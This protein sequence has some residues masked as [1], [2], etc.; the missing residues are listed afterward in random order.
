MEWVALVV[1]VLGVVGAMFAAVLDRQRELAL[2]RALGA[3][4][5]QLAA[6]L[7][8]EAAFLAL[9]AG[10]GGVLAG[11]PMGWIFVRVI[12]E[13]STGW[14]LPYDFPAHEALRVV[15]LTIGVAALAG[16]LVSPKGA[17][18]ELRR[19]LQED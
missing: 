11:L 9:V 4:A 17:R 16:L 3:G 14:R 7:A 19:A 12:G 8:L 6:A 1:A 15:A 13:S 2:L 10:I 5:G 18:A